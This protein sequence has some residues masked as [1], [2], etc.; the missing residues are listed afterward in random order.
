[1]IDK[2]AAARAA[3]AFIS[4]HGRKKKAPR[5]PLEGLME[6]P[7]KLSGRASCSVG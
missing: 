7:W 6:G 4:R 5:R 2:G 3:I 1:M